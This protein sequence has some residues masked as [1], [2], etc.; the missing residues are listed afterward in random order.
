MLKDGLHFYDEDNQKLVFNHYS[1]CELVKWI[2]VQYGNKSYDEAD[3]IVMESGLAK[4]VRDFLDAALIG[5]ET[6]YYWAMNVL[7]GNCY[8]LKGIKVEISFTE[9]YNLW[10]ENIISLNNLCKDIIE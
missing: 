4:P 8:W 7:Y 2:I 3:R 9:E 10:E 6:P 5:H 1:F